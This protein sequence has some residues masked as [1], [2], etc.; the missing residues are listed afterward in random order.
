MLSKKRQ[1]A[2]F[3]DFHGSLAPE[4]RPGRHVGKALLRKA[5]SGLPYAPPNP[6]EADGGYGP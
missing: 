6:I 4:A 5:F 3:R 2:A 1:N